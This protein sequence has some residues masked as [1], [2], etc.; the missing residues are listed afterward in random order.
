MKTLFLLV[1]QSKG[2]KASGFTL[3]LSVDNTYPPSRQTVLQQAQGTMFTMQSYRPHLPSTDAQKKVNTPALYAKESTTTRGK[4][5]THIRLF[6][7][8]RIVMSPALLPFQVALRPQKTQ[9]AE[10]SRIF[11]KIIT[12]IYRCSRQVQLPHPKVM[13]AILQAVSRSPRKVGSN[14]RILAPLSD[15]RY[16]CL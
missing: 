15:R 4:I 16:I 13:K 8:N 1:T 11:L 7:S 3:V 5:I 6:E 14:Y 2:R 10:K 12:M 9:F